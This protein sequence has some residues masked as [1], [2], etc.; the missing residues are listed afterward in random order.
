MSRSNHLLVGL[1]ACVAMAAA[2]EFLCLGQA[3]H[4][5][6]PVVEYH[7]VGGPNDFDSSQNI[8]FDATGSFAGSG[9]PR[10]WNLVDYGS[11]GALYE[12]EA[13]FWWANPP[14]AGT[15]NVIASRCIKFHHY[16]RF[17]IRAA[18]FPKN[19]SLFLSLRVKDDLIAPAPVF[20]WT[21]RSDWK[22]IGTVAGQND[23]RWKTTALRVA[24]ADCQA[25]KGT[26]VF[27][28][29]LNGYT[30]S[31]KGELNIDMI[32]LATSEDH[33]RFPADRAGLWPVGPKSKFANLGQ[34]MELVPGQRPFFMYGVY[35][36]DHWISDGGTQNRAGTGAKDSWQILE[37]MGM[38][39]YVVHGWDQNW[40]SQW[41]SYP[42]EAPS[43]YAA[44]G[45]YVRPGLREHLTQAAGHQL[46]VMPNFLTDIMGYWTNR[47]YHGEPNTLAALGKVMRAYGDDPSILAWYPVDEWDHEN[48][49]WG[50]PKLYSHLLNV[51]ARRN[52][53]NRPCFMLCMGFLGTD[54]WKI[55]AEEADILAVDVYPSDYENKIEKALAKQAEYLTDMRSVLGRNTPYVLV[56]ELHQVKGSGQSAITIARTPAE[57]VAQA[58]L[59]IIHGARGILFFAN[60]HPSGPAVPTNLLDGPTQVARELF[61]G[62][63]G[64]DNG[65]ATL[66]LPPSKP[67][68]IVGESKIVK[69]SNRS[70]HASLFEDAQGRRTL[71][72]LNLRNQ[73]V[74]E[75]RLEI[76]NLKGGIVRTR[77]EENRTIRAA[78]GGFADDFDA[79]QRHVYDLPSE[80]VRVRPTPSS[81]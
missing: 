52:S 77:F 7:D 22:Q 64:I 21:G 59:G 35:S 30:P 80:P 67:V 43:K 38:N 76:A 8:F 32:Q 60:C 14:P 9:S 6:G 40:D 58:Y 62:D 13:D 69:C 17:R 26:L 15:L 10:Y 4:G 18:R 25:D 55:A 46:K 23:H 75:V 79:L 1:T 19:A 57:S 33:S 28:V 51:E 2:V 61:R 5:D 42:D 29:G 73:P 49:S 65:L 47:Q 54:T 81:T 50:K 16:G 36:G 53:P 72:A 34:T 63:P 68:D 11:N 20:V 48:E 70:I 44:P 39:T 45:V 78:R 74:K 66:L 24:A 41:F 3:A 27:K 37:N 56:P 31:I 71:I 12:N